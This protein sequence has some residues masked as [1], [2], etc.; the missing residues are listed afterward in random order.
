M[1]CGSGNRKRT[2]TCNDP[3]PKCNGAGCSGSDTEV[4]SCSARRCNL[5]EYSYIHSVLN[6]S[7]MAF[8]GLILLAGPSRVLAKNLKKV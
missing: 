4:G 1:T 8:L 3:S 6:L 5:G 2:R 7:A